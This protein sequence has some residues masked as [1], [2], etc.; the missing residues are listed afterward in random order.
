MENVAFCLI[1]LVIPTTCQ[2]T[3]SLLLSLLPDTKYQCN[4]LGCSPSNISSVKA[5]RDCQNACLRNSLCCTIN[6]DRITNQC[7]IFVD[8]PS[9]YGNLILQTDVITMI[10]IDSRPLSAGKY[11]IFFCL[12]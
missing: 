6:F 5:I 12:V 4:D 11:M 10:A 8:T 1:L 7:E 3:N 9:Q 2:H